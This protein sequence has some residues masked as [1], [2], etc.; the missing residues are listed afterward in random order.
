[1]ALVWDVDDIDLRELPEELAGQMAEAAGARGSEVERP[2]LRTRERD[3]LL[4][5]GRSHRRRKR[6]DERRG[7]HRRYR[8]EPFHRVVGKLVQRGVRRIAASHYEQRVAVWIG[9]HYEVGA[10]PA[11]GAGAVVHDEVLAEVV[12]Q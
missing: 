4:Q 8:R 2:W 11:P 9:L 5:V 12:A 1:I 3:E 10:E 6:E 7:R